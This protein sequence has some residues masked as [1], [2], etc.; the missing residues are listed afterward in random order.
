MTPVS[1]T[2][3]TLN[4]AANIEACLASVAW[5]DEVLVVDSGSTDAR[6][7]SRRRTGAR[8]IVR[9]WPG[10]AR[11][12]ELRR[13]RGR[14]RLD[15]LGRRR[16]ARHAGAGR[17]DPRAARPV[18]RGGRVPHPARHVAPRPLDSHHRLVSRLPAAPLRPAARALDGAARARVGHGRRPGRP[19]RRRAPALRL[20]RPQ[21]SPSRRWTGTRR[22]RPRT[23]TRDGRRAGVVGPRVPSAGGV[24]AQLR[25]AP[26]V[27]R[28]HARLHHLGDERVLRVPE[29]RQAVGRTAHA[30]DGRRD[31]V[32][33]HRH[34][35]D[36][37]RR[38]EPGPAHCHRPRGARP[39]G[40]ARR[41]R[42]RRAASAGRSE[43]LRFVGF[44]PR[45][46]FDVHAAWQLGRI[47]RDV[48]PDVVHAHDPMG[49]ALAAMAL[50]MQTGPTPRPLVV[51]SRRVDFHLKRHAFSKWKYRQVDV[52]IAASHVI[53]GM[54]EADGIAARPHR[55]R[56]RRRQPRR[57]STSS[58]VVDAHATFWLPHG[59][60]VVGN[61]AALVPHKGQR[62]LVA[63]AARVRPRGA[64]RAVPHRRRGRAARAARAA[65]Q[66]PRP[67]AARAPARIPRRRARPDEVVRPVRD[68]LG[69]RRARVGGA[70]GDGVPPRRR[71]HA[72]RRHSRGRRRRR[73]GPARAAARRRRARRARS[74][75][76]CA[77]PSLRQ[78]AR[79]RRRGSGSRTSSASSGW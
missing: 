38:P 24:P 63:A 78:T 16:R 8:V 43:G 65:D 14:A 77:T 68:E 61:V 62:H 6:S 26:R 73:D 20:P 55:R 71:R 23:C 30:V 66:G 48:K 56:A 69:H 59:A 29:V 54:L 34:G 50:Q 27:P 18:R 58:R 1:V 33:P 3:I 7:T 39:P 2:V 75:G 45:S 76:C 19:A 67:R 64:R 70:R 72:R 10:Y 28:R 60:P 21:P 31:H 74:S 49:V 9:D 5:A 12:E 79:R 40:R 51:A 25:P 46:E 4:E 15:P 37:A 44:A 41:A 36:L 17:G 42:R 53:A 57:R 47:L 11:A 52:F 35:R 22:W 32:R 13:R